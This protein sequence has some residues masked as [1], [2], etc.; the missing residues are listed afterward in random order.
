MHPAAQPIRPNFGLCTAAL[1]TVMLFTGATAAAGNYVDT[2]QLRADAA[3]LSRAVIDVGA[4]SLDI[5]GDDAAR[6]VR[7]TATVWMEDAPEDA[8]RVR[9]LIDRHVEL[10]LEAD[11]QVLRLTTSTRDPGRG[12][13]LPHV[14]LEVVLPASLDLDIEDRSG[15]IEVVHMA[16][17]VKIEDD[18]GSIRVDDIGG[19][20]AIDDDSGSIEVTGV[21]GSVGIEDESGSIVVQQVE[22]DVAIDDQSGSITVRDVGGSVTLRDGSGSILVTGVGQDLHVLEAGSGSETFIDVAGDITVDD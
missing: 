14:D 2:R 18:S 15:W 12:Y 20:V 11:G 4:G 16:G 9:E 17:D 21:A 22:G 7:V 19:R 5:R 10:R 13:S 6:E 1:A 8:E 3:G